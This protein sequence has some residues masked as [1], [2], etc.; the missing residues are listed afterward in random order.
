MFRKFEIPPLPS[1]ALNITV[2]EVRGCRW[3]RARSQDAMIPQVLVYELKETRRDILYGVTITSFHR[4]SIRAV[5]QWSDRY[6]DTIMHSV[7]KQHPIALHLFDIFKLGFAS[8]DVMCKLA[9]HANAKCIQ[10]HLQLDTRT[11]VGNG[12]YGPYWIFAD[13]VGQSRPCLAPHLAPRDCENVVYVKVQLCAFIEK[14][15]K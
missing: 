6:L 2:H 8:V 7:G 1:Q 15:C 14:T 10:V 12:V 11:H 4:T 13:A 3:I 9:S 5:F